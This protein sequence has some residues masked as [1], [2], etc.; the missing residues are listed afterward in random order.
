MP[1]S[2]APRRRAFTLIELLVVVLIISILAAIA[3]PNFLEAHTR[4]K[5]TRA[6]SDLRAMATALAAYTVDHNK[7]FPDMNDSTTD[8]ALMGLTFDV[9]NGRGPDLLYLFSGAGQY[10]T[11]RALRPMTTPIAYMTSIPLDPFSRVMPIG[12][13]TREIDSRI[14]YA[15]IFS[16]GPDRIAGHW[17]RDYTGEGRAVTYDPT[18]GTVSMGEIW[19]AVYV[20]DPGVFQ[21]EYGPEIPQ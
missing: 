18:N 6:K 10:Y 3:V 1:H 9:E 7:L 19:R 20:A 13:D 14:V 16:S 21:K 5:V 4:A 8:P 2:Q 17:H 11:F 15:A 12:Y